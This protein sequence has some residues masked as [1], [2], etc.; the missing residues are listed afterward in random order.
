MRFA[1]PG[2]SS[3]RTPSNT[4]RRPPAASRRSSCRVSA[5]RP[6]RKRYAVCIPAGCSRSTTDA[7]FFARSPASP[8]S[9]GTAPP[10][11]PTTLVTVLVEHHPERDLRRRPPHARRAPARRVLLRS[12]L[13]KGGGTGPLGTVVR[14]RESRGGGGG[15]NGLLLFVC[16]CCCCVSFSSFFVLFFACFF[17]LWHFC[18][19]TQMCVRSEAAGWTS[20]VASATR[21]TSPVS[22]RGASTCRR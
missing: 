22:C 20:G 21:L 11:T 5:R 7:P 3:V 18:S 4:T 13:C 17:F 6:R 19:A 2:I 1:I 10:R 16:F 9:R 8:S 15:V 12:L 14:E